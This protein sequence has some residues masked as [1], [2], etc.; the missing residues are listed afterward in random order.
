MRRS[1]IPSVAA[2]GLLAA[3]QPQPISQA[4]QDALRASVATFVAAVNAGNVDG[5][6]AAF[7]ADATV[8]P[9]GMPAAVG[10]AAARK[11]WTDMLAAMK[12][13][14]TTTVTKV[15]GQGDVGYAMGTYHSSGTMRDSTQAAPPPEDGHWVVVAWRQADK[16][17]K[18]KSD[19]W[20]ANAPPAAPAPAPARRH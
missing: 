20:S 6:A 4:D 9:P 12:F 15:A 7:T 1:L 17:W 2:L 19:T 11:L 16:S 8:Q 14:L 10:T 5:M 18:W 3:C 13:N